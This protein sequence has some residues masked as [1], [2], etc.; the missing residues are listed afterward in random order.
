MLSAIIFDI[1]N[2]LLPFDFGTAIQKV[3]DQVRVRPNEIFDRVLP[4]KDH[5]ETGRIPRNE[6]VRGAMELIGYRGEEQDFINA[7]QDIFTPNE[8]LHELVGKL[9]D[10]YPLY[11][12]S[13]TSDLHMDY[14]VE[15]YPVF[16]LFRDGVFSHIAGSMKPDPAIYQHTIEKLGVAPEKTLFI[17]DLAPNLAAA[18]EFGFHTFHYDHTRHE[19]LVQELSEKY[20][21]V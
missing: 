17:D 3:A 6:F 8:P 18:R 7:W 16:S 5:Y 10:R 14:I 2:V 11:L 15:N 4:L 1:G 9:A 21:I 13:N 20:G 12:L 19:N